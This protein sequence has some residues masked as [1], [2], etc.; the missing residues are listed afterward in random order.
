MNSIAANTQNAIEIQWSLTQARFDEWLKNDL[1]HFEW[2]LLLALFIIAAYVWWR[3]VD[4]SRLSEMI[5]YTALV[6]IMILVL[7]ELGEELALW[8]YPVDIIPIFPP[9][10]AIDLACLPFLYSLMYQI[11]K[12]WKSFIITSIVMSAVS[13]FVLEPI[14]VWS[15]IYQMLTWKGYYGFP[16]YFAIAVLARAAVER[17]QSIVLKQ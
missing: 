5:L 1:F 8:D 17:I 7:D 2:W 3:T 14:F 10:S 13:C 15:G 11:F 9:I 4:K 12:T 16:L 6:M